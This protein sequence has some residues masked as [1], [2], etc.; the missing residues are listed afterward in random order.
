[1]SDFIDKWL[2]DEE[3]DVQPSSFPD[4]AALGQINALALEMER[5]DSQ[6]QGIE[7]AMKA[8]R[9]RYRQ[10][11]LREMPDLLQQAGLKS[12]KLLDGSTLEVAP[13]YYGNISEGNREAAHEWLRANGF[14]GIIKNE[15][16]VA[17]GMGEDEKAA[18]LETKL[19][20]AGY[21]FDT[22]EG[23]HSSTLKAFVR[24]QFENG[25]AF[26]AELFGAYVETQAAVERPK[27][28]RSNQ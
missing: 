8:N 28:K 9:E 1:M 11:A 12:C 26:P 6:L 25:K 22:K 15:Y 27:T 17:F 24:E 4:E 10:I 2:E 19:R 14:A 3:G 18:E 7:V 16:K 5:L 20:E 23:V 13:K 21:Q